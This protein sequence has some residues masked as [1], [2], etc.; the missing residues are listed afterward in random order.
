M[1]LKLIT[2]I[3][4]F[5]LIAF[6]IY[7]LESFKIKSAAD[8]LFALYYLRNH[9]PI[10]AYI[11]I[12]YIV[13]IIIIQ[14]GLLHIV[15]IAL[16]ILATIEMFIIYRHIFITLKTDD[17]DDYIDTV[18]K[19]MFST[20]TYSEYIEIKGELYKPQPKWKLYAT[21]M[22]VFLFAIWNIELG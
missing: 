19:R 10:L 15:D 5:L 11:I 1:D 17:K 16:I 13:E 7:I 4:V 18:I 12:F 14:I 21:E 20:L 3:I 8:K 2:E 6:R 9:H 22:F